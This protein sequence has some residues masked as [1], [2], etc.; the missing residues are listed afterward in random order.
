MLHEGDVVEEIA[1]G[2]RGV[3]DSIGSTLVNKQEIQNSW[4]V[5]FN[6]GKEPLSKYFTTEADLRLAECPHQNQGEPG[7]YPSRPIM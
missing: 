1:T 3:V 7:F 5:R 2:R 6:D 4:R